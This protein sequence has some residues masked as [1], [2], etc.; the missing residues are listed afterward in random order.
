MEEGSI[1]ICT[2]SQ[3]QETSEQFDGNQSFQNT[4]QLF[5]LSQRQKHFSSSLLKDI[6]EERKSTVVFTKSRIGFQKHPKIVRQ[7]LLLCL[8]CVKSLKAFISD[9]LETLCSIFF[10]TW[11]DWEALE[12]RVW[13]PQIHPESNIQSL[14]LKFPLLP[15]C[16]D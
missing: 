15:L 7:K 16:F 10:T 6:L 3:K 1:F 14:P 5:L 8:T 12:K 13:H 11:D 9:C 4:E 2:H